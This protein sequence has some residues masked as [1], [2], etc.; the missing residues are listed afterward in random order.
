MPNA[1]YFLCRLLDS[2]R[3]VLTERLGEWPFLPSRCFARIPS[4]QVYSTEKQPAGTC[5]P[6]FFCAHRWRW[7][8]T[9]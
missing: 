5:F 4:I 6:V 3:V 1:V 9:R 8:A 2:P 7:A